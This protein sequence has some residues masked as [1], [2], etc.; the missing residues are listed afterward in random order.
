MEYFKILLLISEHPKNF[1]TKKNRRSNQTMNGVVDDF[2][3]NFFDLQY[4][5]IVS[6]ISYKKKEVVIMKKKGAKKST[7]KK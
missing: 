2:S 1:R 4:I 3:G 7:K 5:Y 6:L